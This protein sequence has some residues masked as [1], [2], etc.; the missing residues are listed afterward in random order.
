MKKYLGIDASLFKYNRIYSRFIWLGI[1][2]NYFLNQRLEVIYDSLA[3][4]Q[5]I[6]A[7]LFKIL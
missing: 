2:Y 3:I 6:I 7:W 1:K 5:R 4:N